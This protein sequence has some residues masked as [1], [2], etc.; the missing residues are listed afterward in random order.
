MF[1]Q[2]HDFTMMEPAM[3]DGNKGNGERYTVCI[4]FFS[5]LTIPM[6]VTLTTNINT[7]SSQCK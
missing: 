5:A 4:I 2:A 3:I 7:A 1:D 6:L